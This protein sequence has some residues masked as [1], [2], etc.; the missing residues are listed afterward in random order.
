MNHDVMSLEKLLKRFEENRKN[1]KKKIN[2]EKY[3]PKIYEQGNTN[4]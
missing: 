4:I 2:K 1:A 3:L